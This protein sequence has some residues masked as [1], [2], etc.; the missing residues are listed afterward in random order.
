MRRGRPSSFPE[1]HAR[2]SPCFPTSLDC[3]ASDMTERSDPLL[4]LIWSSEDRVPVR[5]EPVVLDG[6]PGAGD[7]VVSLLAAAAYGLTLRYAGPSDIVLRLRTASPSVWHGV[8][9]GYPTV[10]DGSALGPTLRACRD[11]LRAAVPDAGDAVEETGL[12]EVT[13]GDGAEDAAVF[14]F[15]RDE[16]GRWS[17]RV[18]TARSPADPGAP[19]RIAAH[20]AAFVRAAVA[21][22]GTRVG[23]VSYLTEAD[24]RVAER[25]NDPPRPLDG[26]ECIHTLIEEST[27]RHP[28]AIAVVQGSERLT[29]KQLDAKAGMLAA[30]LIDNGVTPGDRVGL[31]ATRSVEFV[32]AV[33]AI[34]KSG[35]AYVPFDPL[36]PAARLSTLFRL[37]SVRLL[38]VEPAHETL[39][40]GLTDAWLVIPWAH[41]MEELP[42]A[43]LTVPVTSG[44]ALAYIIFT[45]GSSGEPKGTLLDHRG[46]VNMFRDLN[47]RFGIGPTD[48]VLVV[49][50]PSF[51]M[52][53]YDIFGSLA[54]GARVVLPE[55]GREYDVQSWV[56][57]AR[58]EEVTV[59]HSVPSAL[60]L[61]LRTWEATASAAG[62]SGAPAGAL[63]L[64]LLGGDWIPV[65]Q[66][67][68][69][70]R[71]FPGADVYSL[72]GAT[73]V[74]V[75]SVIYH[76]TEVRP[77]WRSIPYG[78][79][80]SNQ[81]AYIVDSFGERAAIDQAGELVLGGV[82]VGWGY[83]GR[84]GFTAERFVPDPFGTE[85]G[86]RLYRTG[87]AARLRP[88]G[89]I[90]LLGRLDQQV[91]LEGV[92]IELGEI[93]S[94]LR[95]YP[96]VSEAVV[97]P[98]RDPQGRVS[99]LTAF[100]VPA[101][102]D[103]DPAAEPITAPAAGPAWERELR[104]HLEATLPRSMVPQRIA[105]IDALPVN[106]NGKVDRRRLEALASGDRPTDPAARSRSARGGAA[107][108]LTLAVAEVW[109]EVLGLDEVPAPDAV[110]QDLGG[111]SLAAMQ[112]ASRLNGRF[113]VNV[114]L[115]DLYTKASVTE[116]A[117]L[118]REHRTESPPM[119]QLVRRRPR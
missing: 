46:R 85:P 29:Y 113:S 52:S 59:W 57:L 89:H 65:D 33:L 68:H 99:S 7:N 20:V 95:R 107:D 66:P 18:R 63:R 27:R 90:E 100:V 117:Q 98:R 44:D 86:R 13:A 9:V 10:H 115:T 74:S 28:D 51:D 104:D 15:E 91:K 40:A 108:Q 76:V 16:R 93:Q 12:V 37:A 4:P 119:P 58:A 14:A 64:F 84:P 97:V 114:K 50:S 75:D 25:V 19:D 118:L 116:V 73:E 32:V 92:R 111:T 105:V 41:A 70:W 56:G 2:P 23:A 30:R 54:A 8:D 79:A 87:D 21:A 103:P 77:D 55:R 83:D 82:G 81:T 102:A 36:S 67:E 49:S 62:A 31:L 72:G 71:S 43:R 1:W 78:R 106:A 39:A 11:R 42:P 26:A 24:R 96:R 34:L 53:V 35:A 45:S 94:C 69:I 6:V 5:S 101:T 80:L 112:V 88:D 61:F 38:L 17:V 110:F 47:E 22:P 3:G 109:A 48:R 60:Q